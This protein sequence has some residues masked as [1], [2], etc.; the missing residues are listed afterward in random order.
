[1]RTVLK[2]LVGLLAAAAVLLG[3]TAWGKNNRNDYI[4]IYGDD[5]DLF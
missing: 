5:E 4:E 1:M 2:F 3:I